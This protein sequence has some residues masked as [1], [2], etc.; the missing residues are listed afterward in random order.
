MVRK[1]TII[2][3]IVLALLIGLVFY[4]QKNPLPSQASQTPSPTP[5][6]QVLPDIHSSDITWVEWKEKDIPVI[7]ISREA[8]GS[9]VIGG[10][11]NKVVETAKAEQLRVE[12]AA[13]RVIAFMPEDTSLVSLGLDAPAYVL[14]LRTAGGEQYA[15]S[16]GKKTSIGNGY[17]IRVNDQSPAAVNNI[18]VE[19]I[20]DLMQQIISPPPTATVPPVAPL[21]LPTIGP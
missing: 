17:F 4:L 15:I 12:I 20:Q 7:Q 8:Q 3:L 14:N 10:D 6:A 11:E 5:Q 1:S 18:V 9:W 13:M 2:M 16:I 21:I 19:T